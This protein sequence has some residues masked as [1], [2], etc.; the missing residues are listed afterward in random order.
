VKCQQREPDVRNNGE[1]NRTN[2]HGRDRINRQAD[3]DGE[4]GN[5]MQMERKKTSKTEKQ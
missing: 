2:M 5:V 3:T 1:A 4:R